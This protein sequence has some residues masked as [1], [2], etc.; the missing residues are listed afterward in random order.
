MGAVSCRRALLVRRG[1]RYREYDKHTAPEQL[2]QEEKRLVERW[3]NDAD[4]QQKLRDSVKR[5]LEHVLEK[6][7]EIPLQAMYRCNIKPHPGSSGTCSCMCV[8]V[9]P[10]CCS[11]GCG[12]LM[13]RL[14][15]RAGVLP[16]C[17]L[18]VLIKLVPAPWV[19]HRGWCA[20]ALMVTCK[21]LVKDPASW[22]VHGLIC[23]TL[24]GSSGQGTVDVLYWHRCVCNAVQTLNEMLNQESNMSCALFQPAQCAEYGKRLCE[25]LAGCC[26]L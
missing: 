17:A 14:S 2:R 25:W 11:P 26:L 12:W 1:K 4:E 21:R 15:Y 13:L 19:C 5:V 10:A 16:V 7:E 23:L 20:A 22:G 8:C 9:P 24:W 6:H 18:A 3:R